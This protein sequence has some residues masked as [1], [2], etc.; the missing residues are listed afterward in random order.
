MERSIIAL[1]YG[2]DRQELWQRLPAGFTDGGNVLHADQ[3]LDRQENIFS[4]ELNGVQSNP[5]IFALS[6]TPSPPLRLRNLE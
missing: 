6:Q 3:H 5:V 2:P 1:L 4:N